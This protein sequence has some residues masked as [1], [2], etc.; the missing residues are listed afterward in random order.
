M[1]LPQ[2]FIIFKVTLQTIWIFILLGFVVFTFLIWN[3]GVKEGFDEE[4]LFDFSF[5]IV[6]LS[7]TALKLPLFFVLLVLIV[8]LSF[9]PRLLW[10]WSPFRIMDIFTLAFLIAAV[11][12]IIGYALILSK[13]YLL[14]AV[15]PLIFL[16]I[17]FQKVRNIR[18][19]SGH[20]F[21]ATLFILAVLNV[22]Y[23]PTVK[24]LL[25]SI[26]LS[27]IALIIVYLREKKSM[28]KPNL[29][30][31][32]LNSLKNKLLA[33]DKRLKTEQKIL[34]Q[35]DPY[36]EP[37][38]D[39]SNG[40]NMDEALLEDQKKEET[41]IL[42]TSITKMQIQVRRALAKMRIGRYGTC[43]VCGKPIDK[44]RLEI[45]PEATTC[46]EHA[47]TTDQN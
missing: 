9:I 3:Y 47:P 42:S 26:I 4:K 17:I 33:K 46:L 12:V 38:R 40:E 28:K 18:I 39:V 30:L 27:I 32:F 8:F 13:Y 14:L 41:D 10:K 21:A 36:M 19:R 24:Y 35:E 23:H 6:L 37:D 34:V 2:H 45:Y 25:F 1:L 5:L 7:L 22:S 20:L 29:S 16:Y 15:I 44:A 31:D 11:P 43:E